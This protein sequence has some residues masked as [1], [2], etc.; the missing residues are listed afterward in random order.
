M[1]CCLC[2]SFLGSADRYD[3][4]WLLSC[5]KCLDYDMTSD[6]MSLALRLDDE[7]KSRL[8]ETGAAALKPRGRRA[9]RARIDLDALQRLV[10][11]AP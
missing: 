9:R 3:S 11:K 1:K 4:F 2:G 6:A 10:A 5:P 8:F 7:A